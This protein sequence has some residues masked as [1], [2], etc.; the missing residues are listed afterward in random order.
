MKHEDSIIQIIIPDHRKPKEI[1]HFFSQ[2]KVHSLRKQKTD[3]MIFKLCLHCHLALG[4]IKHCESVEVHK[5]YEIISTFI[6]LLKISD[7]L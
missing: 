1:T 7:Y 4:K 5:S 3:S 6:P 2:N